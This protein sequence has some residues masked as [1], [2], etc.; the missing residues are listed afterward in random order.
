MKMWCALKVFTVSSR[1]S[2]VSIV[3]TDKSNVQQDQA[4]VDQAVQ[5]PM[6]Q[7]V[8]QP[9]V[10]TIQQLPYAQPS[11]FPVQPQIAYPYQAPAPS[12]VYFRQPLK[13]Q[14]VQRW[15]VQRKC[16]GTLCAKSKASKPKAPPAKDA[17]T[18]VAPKPAPA[19][20]A[21]QPAPPA[22]PS[23]F[24]VPG[25]SIQMS[26]VTVTQGMPP[27]APMDP[28]NPYQAQLPAPVVPPYQ[29]GFQGARKRKAVPQMPS[30][31]ESYS[32]KRCQIF[33]DWPTGE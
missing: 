8:Q 10:Q 33:M 18:K 20:Q 15:P 28:Y 32:E 9:A 2:I 25:A 21:P 14:P 12:P 13:L 7:P 17:A 29:E 23:T 27:I 4:Q 6:Q 11:T 1:F 24:N 3:T 16:F 5:Q 19:P 30:D 22:G 31:C 26:P